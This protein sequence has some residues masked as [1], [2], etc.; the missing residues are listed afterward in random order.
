VSLARLLPSGLNI[1]DDIVAMEGQE[2][3]GRAVGMRTVV[4]SRDRV[5]ADAVA[6]AI[7]GFSEGEVPHLALAAEMGLGEARL[8][9]IN[10][11]GP[12]ISSVRRGF[13]RGM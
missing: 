10:V 12:P 3:H 1:I 13:K 2:I 8:A 5:A 11:V 6:A 4:A 7:M 9:N